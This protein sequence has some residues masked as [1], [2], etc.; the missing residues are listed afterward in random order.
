M[1]PRHRINGIDGLRAFA[2]IAVVLFHLNRAFMPGGFVGVD[3]F[4]VIS[5]YVVCGSLLKDREK[6]FT[7]FISAFYLRRLLRIYP[8][9]V[10]LLLTGAILSTLFIPYSYLSNGNSRIGSWALFGLSNIALVLF[11][12]DYFSQSNDFN[13]YAHTWSL[14]VE[15]QYYLIFPLILF[16]VTRTKG[17]GAIRGILAKAILPA[18]V[19]AS[20]VACITETLWH[21]E[22]AYFLLHGR[23]WEL[24]AGALLC[25]ANQKGRLLPSSARGAAAVVTAGLFVMLV[26]VWV[27]DPRFFPFPLAVPPVLGSMLCIAGLVAPCATGTGARFLNHPAMVAIGRMSYSIYLW[28]WLI[29]VV[30]RWTV[31]SESIYCNLAALVLTFVLA[32]ASYHW[33]EIPFQRTHSFFNN[34]RWMALAGGACVIFGAYLVNKRIGG[35]K[36]QNRIGLSE[37]TKKRADWY[38]KCNWSDDLGPLFAGA[39]GLHWS[40]KRLFSLGDSH[41][42]TYG[43][44]FRMLEEKDGVSVFIDSRPGSLLGSLV[45]PAGAES[46]QL[47]AALL[48][49]VRKYC[50][51]GDVVLLSN[52]RVPKFS[53]QTGAKSDQEMAETFRREREPD[54]LA[55]MEEGKAL[56]GKLK[57]LG[58][59]VIIDAPM[60]VFKSPPFRGVDWFN[61]MN[62]AVRQGFSMDRDLLLAHRGRAMKSIEQVKSEIPDIHVWDPFWP[63]CAGETVTAFEGSMPVFFDGDHL[64]DYGGRKLYPS[65][66]T[67]LAKIWN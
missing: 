51:P 26:S 54:R 7:T 42:A 64:T 29:I 30:M 16:W 25:M 19:V 32:A 23:F 61:R 27:A 39:R 15:E 53:E 20:F 6:G 48:E 2:V 40:D 12:N 65:L 41:A 46:K 67:T 14:G 33:V 28:H 10:V 58:L 11:H 4:F 63:L 47:E 1:P 38:P 36:V 49:Q 55:A 50:R 52:L 24:G 62:P 3:V 60:P 45:Y 22:R 18:L 17:R 43:G 8:A 21:H 5:G 56:I 13:P 66:K 31:G 9:L 44:L 59:H 57:Q 34:R 35:S 37:V